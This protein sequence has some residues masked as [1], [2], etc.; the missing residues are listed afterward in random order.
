M[1]ANS[2][3]EVK[4]LRPHLASVPY[5][6]RLQG[7]RTPPCSSWRCEILQGELLVTKGRQQQNFQKPSL[8]LSSSLLRKRPLR[9]TLAGH[10]YTVVC[11]AIKRLRDDGIREEPESLHCF[12]PSVMAM[13]NF[14]AGTFS[15]HETAA[16]K[17][18]EAIS[19]S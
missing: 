6:R 8:L 1:N 14:A 11:S 9:E 2:M 7:T 3:P 16:A 15:E 13:R 12:T 4:A 17:F 18:P 10:K 19:I 5:G